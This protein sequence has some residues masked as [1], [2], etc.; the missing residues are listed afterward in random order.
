MCGATPEARIVAACSGGSDSTALV[1]LLVAAGRPPVVCAHLDHGLRSREEAEAEAEI[2]RRHCSRFDLRYEDEHLEAGFLEHEA[3]RTGASLEELARRERYRF[4]SRVCDAAGA[5]YLAVGHTL[6]DQSETVLMRLLQGSDVEGLAG[7][8]DCGPVPTPGGRTAAS[9]GT[10]AAAGER[11]SADDHVVPR[12]LRPLLDLERD[13]LR[14]YLREQGLAF[15][16]DPSNTDTRYLRNALRSEILPVVERHFPSYKR[17][18]ARSARRLREASRYVS[19]ETRRRTAGLFRPEERGTGLTAERAAFFSLPAVVRRRALY[20]AL[21][22]VGTGRRRVP[23][24]FV[25]SVPDENGV[26]TRGIVAR[27]H[28]VVIEVDELRIVV[29]R[30]VVP[31]GDRGYLYVV[32]GTPPAGCD[33]VLVL[34][35]KGVDEAVVRLQRGQVLFPVIARS[36]RPGDSIVLPAGSRLL[37]RVFSDLGVAQ[38]LRDRAPI[39]EDRYGIV[40]VWGAVVGFESLWRR[41]VLAE[42]GGDCK[43]E[44]VAVDFSEVV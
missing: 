3:A 27:G 39:L 6:D 38:E 16:D 15:V 13:E 29:R 18:I 10:T 33:P 34:S 17:G 43:S 9:A 30:D 2:V 44:P 36:R 42:E 20:E 11:S 32:V 5:E 25:D 1:A 12:I 26:P 21:G 23:S 4:L 37:K 7:I 24:R 41:G 31:T 28:G 35:A 22:R 8:E 40:G 19:A 14:A